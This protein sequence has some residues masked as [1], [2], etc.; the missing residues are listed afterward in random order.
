MHGKDDARKLSPV[1]QHERRRQI[2][3]AHKLARI[4][5]QIA[6]EVGL[7]YMAVMQL[8]ERESGVALHVRSAG[9]YL[10]A[11]QI[12]GLKLFEGPIN[13]KKLAVLIDYFKP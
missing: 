7:S 10:R 5:S 13:S 1:E 2:V 6:G 9:K 4:Q 3:W 11:R 12:C 8:I